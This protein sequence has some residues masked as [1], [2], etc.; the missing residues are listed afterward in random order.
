MNAHTGFGRAVRIGPSAGM[1]TQVSHSAQNAT[2]PEPIEYFWQPVNRHWLMAGICFAM[3]EYIFELIYYGEA[4]LAPLSFL[5]GLAY[6]IYMLLIML[7]TMWGYVMI[8]GNP[9]AVRMDEKGIDMPATYDRVIPWNS[10]VAIR[11]QSILGLF[12]IVHLTTHRNLGL[13]CYSHFQLPGGERNREADT[14]TVTKAGIPVWMTNGQVDQVLAETKR[15]YEVYGTA[16]DGAGPEEELRF[17]RY[18]TI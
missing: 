15:F 10:I 3:I 18:H 16:P 5:G 12:K 7:G 13:G 8:V 1:S 11:T 14:V 9:Y 2:P 17:D 4:P 6:L